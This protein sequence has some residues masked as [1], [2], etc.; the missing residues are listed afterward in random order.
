LTYRQAA[1]RI[2]EVGGTITF[3]T[4]SGLEKGRQVW[5]MDAIEQVAAAYGVD[6]IMLMPIPGGDDGADLLDVWSNGGTAGVL[7]WAVARVDAMVSGERGG[8]GRVS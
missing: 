6:P 3:G 8:T 7:K 4:L 5:S 1:A 2:K